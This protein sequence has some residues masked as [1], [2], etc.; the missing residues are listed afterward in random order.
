[1]STPTIID[2][3]GPGGLFEGMF[4]APSW[5]PWR[6]FLASLFGLPMSADDLTVFQRHT[7]RTTAPTVPFREAALVCGRRGGKSRILALLAVWLA[8]R[9]DYGSVTAPGETP[10]VAII[11]KDRKQAQ[12]ILNYIVGLMTLPPEIGPGRM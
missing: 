6:V 8:C 1:M 4:D 7:V 11:A 3:L 12:V 10:V 2:D 9:P 5:K